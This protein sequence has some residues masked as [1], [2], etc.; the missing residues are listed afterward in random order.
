MYR[1]FNVTIDWDKVNWNARRYYDIGFGIF[2]SYGTRIKA[3]IE[4]FLSDD[5]IIDGA[6]ME[7]DWFPLVQADVLISHSHAD[8]YKAVCLTGYLYDVF[9]VRCFVEIGRAHV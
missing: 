2:R 1:G 9:R 7:S 4:Q 3:G 8:E 5:G 6:Q